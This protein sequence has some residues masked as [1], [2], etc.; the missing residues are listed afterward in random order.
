MASNN[1]VTIELKLPKVQNLGFDLI[2]YSYHTSPQHVQ[3]PNLFHLIWS[4]NYFNFDF[5]L[6]LIHV[7]CS[8]YL[9]NTLT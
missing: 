7:T 4:I 1:L 2:Y 8:N 9:F 5:D 3:Y 6:C